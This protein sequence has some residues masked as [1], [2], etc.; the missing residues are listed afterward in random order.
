MSIGMVFSTVFE[1][2]LVAFTLWAIFH[3]NK[4]IDFEDKLFARIRRRSLRVIK[5]GGTART[6]RPSAVPD[7]F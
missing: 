6:T 7:T 4:F 1:V 5:G 3:E 2:A